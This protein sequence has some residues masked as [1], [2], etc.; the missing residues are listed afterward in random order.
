MTVEQMRPVAKSPNPD[1]IKQVEQLLEDAKEGRV[2]AAMIVLQYD[3][4]STTH[5]W[6]MLK[7]AYSGLLGEALLMLESAA[8]RINGTLRR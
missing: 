4:L 8:H 7:T 3:D 5:Q 6:S 1:L 2:R